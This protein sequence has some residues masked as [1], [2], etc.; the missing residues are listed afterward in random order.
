MPIVYKKKCI[1]VQFKI[2]SGIRKIESFRCNLSVEKRKQS[3]PRSN[4]VNVRQLSP[5]QIVTPV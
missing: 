5:L 1:H 3:L 4:N 2:H